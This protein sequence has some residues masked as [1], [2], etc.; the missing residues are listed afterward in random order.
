MS[1][2]NRTKKPDPQRRWAR[3]VAV[4]PLQKGSSRLPVST[5][6]ES[7]NPTKRLYRSIADEDG[8]PTWGTIVVAY[9]VIIGLAIWLG[10]IVVDLL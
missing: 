4:P 9:S 1:I 2:S 7:T 5:G 6:V 3:A 8:T 10:T